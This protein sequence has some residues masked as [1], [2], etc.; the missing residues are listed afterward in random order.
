MDIS[1]T[2][3]FRWHRIIWNTL[4]FGAA[5][6]KDRFSVLPMFQCRLLWKEDRCRKGPQL[7][8]ENFFWYISELS[9][10]DTL[11]TMI[12]EKIERSCEKLAFCYL[13]EQNLILVASK[14]HRAQAWQAERSPS[15]L[16]LKSPTI[17]IELVAEILLHFAFW[18]CLEQKCHL[19]KKHLKIFPIFPIL[20]KIWV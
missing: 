10:A 17:L 4:I 11:N 18:N 5:S 15:Q 9:L 20:M 6:R 12:W 8:L 2:L 13:S 16:S 19:A 14:T 3:G 1:D 7:F